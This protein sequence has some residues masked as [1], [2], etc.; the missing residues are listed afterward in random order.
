MY[1]VFWGNHPVEV[2]GG[3]VRRI[4]S[5][6]VID[7]VMLIKKGLY[8]VRFLDTRDAVMVAHKGL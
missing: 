2:I 3:F 5:D 1:F 6:Y 8:L 7:R 4:W